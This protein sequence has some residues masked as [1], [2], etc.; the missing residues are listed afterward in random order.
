M[1]FYSI[2]IRWVG[3]VILALLSTGCSSDE[4]PAPQAP[5][6]PP[7]V[8]VTTLAR[9][10]PPDWAASAD[11]AIN[12]TAGKSRRTIKN[13]SVTPQHKSPN[14]LPVKVY[15]PDAN[16]SNLNDQGRQRFE[17]LT[18][19]SGTWD[20]DK[21]F[22]NDKESTAGLDSA[23]ARILAAMVTFKKDGLYTDYFLLDKNWAW[24]HWYYASDLNIIAFD[25]NSSQYEAVF[26]FK[27][28]SAGRFSM[29]LV[30]LTSPTRIR[31]EFKKI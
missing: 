17:W 27:S 21:I 2:G 18:A 29:E 11:S 19:G 15:F 16:G 22:I 23:L 26:Q 24:G 14:A 5:A 9:I 13:P 20:I 7:K 8:N 28:F 30:D 31:V 10:S 3:V 1:N 4:D 25:L 6:G 12:A